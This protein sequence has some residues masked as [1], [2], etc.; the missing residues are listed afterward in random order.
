[1]NEY[2][3]LVIELSCGCVAEI[4]EPRE[5]LERECS[6]AQG[7]EGAELRAHVHEVMR[8]DAAKVRARG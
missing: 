5:R 4:Y 2:W 8:I 1:M 3:P 7:L 6:V